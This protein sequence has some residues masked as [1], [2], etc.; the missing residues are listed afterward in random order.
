M[1]LEKARL[2]LRNPPNQLNDEISDLID[3]ARQDLMRSGVSKEKAE[4]NED[5]LIIK[6][7][8]TYCKAYFGLDDKDAVPVK[9][10]YMESYEKIKQEL[11]LTGDY[12]V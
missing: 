12:R 10:M 6:A 5:P 3:A 4:S 8:V 11:S 7:V 1:L 9:E 2:A